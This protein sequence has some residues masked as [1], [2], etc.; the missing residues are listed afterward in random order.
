MLRNDAEV[1]LDDLLRAVREAADLY[2]D[3][4]EADPGLAPLF[5]DLLRRR[6][7]LAEALT[8]LIRARGGLPREPDEDRETLHRLGHR[9]RAV[10][11]EDGPAELLRDRLDA[12]SELS[13]LAD[14]ALEHA[15]DADSRATLGA[16]RE[17]VAQA[18]QRLAER[19][20]AQARH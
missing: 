17:D 15:V 14:T 9:L 5:D 4:I 13:R 6:Q 18:R 1:S 20:A 19:L 8:G 10:F 7:R 2:A 3:D 11:A 12:E 16:V